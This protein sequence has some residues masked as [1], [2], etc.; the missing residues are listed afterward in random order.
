MTIDDIRKLAIRE[1]E[2]PD[3]EGTGTIKIKVQ[4]PRLMAMAAQGKI[5]NALMGVA[6]KLIKG[7]ANSKEMSITESAQMFQI[8]CL[9]CMVEPT[10]EEMK[11]IIT[12][13]QI[14]MIFNYAID[15]VKKL[16]PF[17]TDKE[18]GSSNNDGKGVPEKAE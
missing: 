15:G 6:T 3:F 4:R 7:T 13:D 11:D 2:I 18:N 12:D 9:S 1:I 16:R 5:P 17:R 8:Y 10:Y 14:M